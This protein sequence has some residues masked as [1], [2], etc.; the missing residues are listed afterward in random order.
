MVV[1]RTGLRMVDIGDA[2]H[3]ILIGALIIAALVIDHF[4]HRRA[5]S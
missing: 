5:R 3:Q 2:V 4:Q 1:L